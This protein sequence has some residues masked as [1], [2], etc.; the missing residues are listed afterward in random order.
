M[1]LK[2]VVNPEDFE[3]GVIVARF[4]VHKLHPSQRRLIDLVCENHKKVIL[5]LGV[6]V[7]PNTERNPLDF[8]TRKVMIQ[9][10]YP[11]IVI[12]PIQDCRSNK[13]WSFNLDNQIRMAFGERTALLYGSRD[14]FIPFYEG[15]FKTTE[16]TT[17]TFYS[18][19]EVRKQV[20]KEI[21]GSED[22][23]AGIIHANYG[24]YPVAYPTVDIACFNNEGQLLLAQ[25]PG[26]DKW[27]FIGGFV[28]PTDETLERAA[29]REFSEESGNCEI[30]ELTYV[31]SHKINDWRYANDK[32]GII[33]TLF[34]GNYIFGSIKPSDD[35]SALKWFDITDF[36]E[37]D[38]E[39]YS[40]KIMFEH[41]PLMEALLNK[42]RK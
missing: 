19:T 39:S 33:T 10:D 30:G 9:N 32:N 1:D 4:Q 36:D 40:D 21:L 34:M 12:L 31:S 27:R 23:R 42:I 35:I 16:L 15:R 22:F 17:D 5:F 3:I 14:S 13:T 28:D 6:S 24:R 7:I 25:K 26:E 29:R 38:Y 2:K 11:N 8:A 41:I 37:D 20:S 18:G